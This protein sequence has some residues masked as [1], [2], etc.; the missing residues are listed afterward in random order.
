[1]HVQPVPQLHHML[2]VMLPM[3]SWAGRAGIVSAYLPRFDMYDQM[4]L[5][6]VTIF[7]MS[8]ETTKAVHQ[9]DRCCLVPVNMMDV[10]QGSGCCKG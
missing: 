1:M 3:A 8:V 4:N 10:K 7:L 6:P 5:W 9:W 2:H